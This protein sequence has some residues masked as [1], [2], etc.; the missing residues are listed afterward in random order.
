MS[1]EVAEHI[2]P[3]AAAIFVDSLVR[4]APVILFSAAIPGQGGVNHVN[5]QWSEYWV[6][7]FEQ[8]GYEVIDCI[9]KKLWQNKGVLWSYAQNILLFVWKD[10]L[11]NY[12]LLKREYE[13]T[14]SS[15]LAI[16][17]QPTIR[18]SVETY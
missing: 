5:E 7:R 3:E 16:V 11:E 17:I 10:C 2:H 9:R 12:S 15:Q 6:E 14:A 8:R 13:R 18:Q 1:L 4:L